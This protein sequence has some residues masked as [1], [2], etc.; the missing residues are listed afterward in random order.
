[1]VFYDVVNSISV[2]SWKQLKLFLSFL[3][4]TNRMLDSEVSC[5]R[6]PLFTTEPCRNPTNEKKKTAIRTLSWTTDIDQDL[7]ARTNQLCF[8]FF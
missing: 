4:F 2:I 1:M 3:G 5:P 8:L 6:T 7:T